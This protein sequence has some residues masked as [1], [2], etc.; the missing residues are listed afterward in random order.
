MHGAGTGCD[1]RP[2]SLT[3]LRVA[4]AGPQGRV[5]GRTIDAWLFP[6]GECVEVFSGTSSH[7][8]LLSDVE[9]LD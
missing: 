2:C 9:I 8:I 6:R 3:G 7:W 5:E 1:C 4:Y